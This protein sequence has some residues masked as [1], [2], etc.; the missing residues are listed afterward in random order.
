MCI[1]AVRIIIS[2]VQLFRALLLAKV[3]LLVL[4]NKVTAESELLESQ[5][6]QN[7]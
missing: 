7:K 5:F 3:L 1:R 2:T 6:T 4:K